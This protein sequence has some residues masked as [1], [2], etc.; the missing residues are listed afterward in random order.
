M[1]SLLLFFVIMPKYGHT[2]FIGKV[3]KLTWLYFTVTEFSKS[4]YAH[5]L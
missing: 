5:G 1:Y 4:N 2:K 3:E